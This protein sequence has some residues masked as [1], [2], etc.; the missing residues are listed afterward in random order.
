MMRRFLLFLSLSSL[1]L[2]INAC[3]DEIKI[4]IPS[5]ADHLVVDGLITDLPG[6]YTVTLSYSNGYFE[7]FNP[8]IADFNIKDLVQKAKVSVI[9]NMGNEETFEEISPGV[10]QSSADGIRGQVGTSYILKIELENG[11]KYESE[12][13]IMPAN[14]GIKDYFIDY[15]SKKF[16]DD[17]LEKTKDGLNISVVPNEFDGTYE[18]YRWRWEG[19][20]EILTFP[21][22]KKDYIP[23]CTYETIPDNVFD[24]RC[25]CCICWITEPSTSSIVSSKLLSDSKTFL[26][27]LE[28][29]EGRLFGKYHFYIQQM[30]MTKEAHEFWNIIKQQEDGSSP[31]SITNT[32]IP[33]NIYAIE[34]KGEI[35]MGYFSAASVKDIAFYIDRSYLETQ[36]VF[37]DTVKNDCRVLKYATNV[38]PI[39][40]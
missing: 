13:E 1:I 20:Y 28:N 12:A 37:M 24:V 19:T 14:V 26:H 40:W 3:I 30:S 11:K 6:P 29:S 2:F 25:K 18:F 15:T 21:E 17:N 5:N 32:E 39:F 36:P 23:P 35:A 8:T 16:L 9:D 7:P 31:F 27:F 34:N 10:Y 38:K 22:L 33:T 4:G